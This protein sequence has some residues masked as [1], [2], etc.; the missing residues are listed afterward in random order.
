MKR[1]K[2]KNYR[3]IS[4]SLLL[5]LSLVGLSLMLARPPVSR[6]ATITVTSTAD[7][8]PGTLRQAIID[9]ASGDTINFSLPAS[10]T[11]TLT[12]AEVLINKSLTISNPALV[13]TATMVAANRQE[14]NAMF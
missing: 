7:S 8:G 12:S 6:A 13:A 2:V 3:V 10:S 1:I 11:I 14:T 5:G 9:A 4:L